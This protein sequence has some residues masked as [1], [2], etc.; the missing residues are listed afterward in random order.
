M[1][2]TAPRALILQHNTAPMA[3]LHAALAKAQ[4]MFE[5]PK[6]TKPVDVKSKEGKHLY[7]FNYAPL[8]EVLAAIKDGMATN[9]LSQGG[10]LA[11]V[12]GQT[13]VRIV[14]RHESGQQI[15]SDYPVFATKEG[16]Q[17]FTSGV[18]YARRNG[19]CLALG[20]A[21][22]DEDDDG[23]ANEGQFTQPVS[24][25]QGK[26]FRVPEPRMP[27]P[28]VKPLPAPP[29]S[30]VYDPETGEVGPHPIPVPMTPEGTPNWI[31]FGTQLVNQLQRADALAEG[32]EWVSQCEA[33][34][35]ECERAAPKVHDRI[36][37]N[38]RVMRQRFDPPADFMT[39]DDPLRPL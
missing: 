39:A 22:A 36:A 19:L 7:T 23:N 33:A 32:E 11:R 10:Y 16:G 14:I 9:G 13:V 17:G 15:E 37:A 30:A 20:I 3:E 4:A 1:N 31:A 8:D 29:Q 2:D 25:G 34:L 6:R 27:A 35:A 18:T 21:P 26:P 28:P 24:Q 38:I 12:D 5:V